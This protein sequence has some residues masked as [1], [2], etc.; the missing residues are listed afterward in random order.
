[1]DQFTGTSRQ[2][3]LESG[4]ISQVNLYGLVGALVGTA[5]LLTG[6]SDSAGVGTI[7]ART[8]SAMVAAERIEASVPE[9]TRVV[10]VT[11]DNDPNNLIGRTNGYESG[12][13][14][15]D[16]RVECSP[17][18]EGTAC[19]A[20]IEQ[21]PTEAGARRRA[22]YITTLQEAAPMLGKE[23]QTIRGRLLLRVSGDLKPSAAATYQSAFEK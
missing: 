18:G 1:M 8:E 19:G 22:E 10:Q 4:T 17:E 3:Q 6:C 20:L 11:E 9:V 14:L 5:L 12:A 7:S 2:E 15:F 16:N 13:I 21:W 23:Y